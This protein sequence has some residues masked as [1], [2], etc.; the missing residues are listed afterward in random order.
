M[1]NGRSVRCR[2]AMG[3]SSKCSIMRF[4]FAYTPESGL[5]EME[6]QPTEKI[7]LPGMAHEAPRAAGAMRLIEVH[8]PEEGRS[9][10]IGMGPLTI[11]RGSDSTVLLPHA[12]VSRHHAQLVYQ[13][14]GLY[15]QDVGSSNGT[16]VNGEPLTAP[17]RLQGGDHIQVGDVM[18]VL[19]QGK[20]HERRHLRRTSLR[21]R[22]SQPRRQRSV[23]GPPEWRQQF[24]VP[25]PGARLRNPA[26]SAK[27]PPATPSL[28][29]HKG[30]GPSWGATT[31]RPV[32]RLGDT[33]HPQ[34]L[35]GADTTGREVSGCRHPR[36]RYH[37]EQFS[38]MPP[39]LARC[40]HQQVIGHPLHSR[41]GH[42]HCD[43][44]R[45]SPADPGRPN[46]GKPLP[47]FTRPRQNS[48]DGQNRQ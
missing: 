47:R 21:P 25:L 10:P 12:S 37:G 36:A 44:L 26:E 13:A 8:G 33:S 4:H 19:S 9:W 35:L 11:G 46:A 18:L 2:C 5:V 15:I 7:A 39:P 29:N 45:T 42:R 41:A 14:T 16:S 23:A 27:I 24:L 30:P 6:A 38:G 31:E 22:G 1:G 34:C 17:R 20:A 40:H 48:E 43:R 32:T 28:T 3:T